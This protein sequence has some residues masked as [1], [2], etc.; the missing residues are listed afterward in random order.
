MVFS[1]KYIDPSYTI[2]SMPANPHDSVFCLLLAHNAV[3]AGM[4]GRTE[5]V[6]GFWKD[7]FT[8]VPVSLAVSKRKRIDPQGRLWSN[9]L[10]STGQ[11]F[12]MV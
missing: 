9:V 2:R 3:H 7:Q 12:H 8:H 1:L 6:V 11:P 5:M 4:N 10:E